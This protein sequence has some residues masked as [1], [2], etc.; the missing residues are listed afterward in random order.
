[1]SDETKPAALSSG[2]PLSG[3]QDGHRL[4]EATPNTADEP[5]WMTESCPGDLPW[6][7]CHASDCMSDGETCDLADGS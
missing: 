5:S 1:V 7:C 3:W 2:W 4:P 6:Y